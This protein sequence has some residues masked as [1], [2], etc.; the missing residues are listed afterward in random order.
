M[1]G[2]HPRRSRA[3]TLAYVF[4][5]A[6]LVAKYA[7]KPPEVRDVWI[8]F[9][10]G[11]H[12]LHTPSML[13]T[14]KRHNVQATFFLV[15]NCAER[16]PEIVRRAVAEGHFIGNHS[17]SHPFLTR[18]DRAA[19]QREIMRADEVLSPFRQGAKLFR[20]P[21]GDH[22]AVVDEVTSAAGYQTILWNLCTRDWSRP[23]QPQRWVQ[24]GMFLAHMTESSVVLMH[25]DLAG[26]AAHLDDFLTRLRRLEVRFMPPETLSESWLIGKF[27]REW[28]D[29]HD[30]G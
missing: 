10:D 17:Y 7:M 13:D 21:H 14:L 3:K 15:G 25:A 22:D 11:P 27:G 1:A 2:I 5:L 6:G 4:D 24:L 8:T 18:L 26:T 23:F 28:L 19:I 12:P 29:V 16:R 20:P 9:D 30:H